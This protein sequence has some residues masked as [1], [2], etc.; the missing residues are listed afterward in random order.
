MKDTAIIKTFMR[1]IN[2]KSQ[3]NLTKMFENCGTSV[4]K[5]THILQIASSYMFDS[6]LNTPLDTR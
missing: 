6:V 4:L 3:V 1:T 5:F 2:N